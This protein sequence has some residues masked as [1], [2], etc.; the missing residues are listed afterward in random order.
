MIRRLLPIA[1]LAVALLVPVSARAATVHFGDPHASADSASPRATLHKAR[2]ALLDG[3]AVRTGA[4]IT[5]LLKQ[6]ALALPSLNGAERKRAVGLL[7]RPTAGEGSNGELEYEAAEQPS[8]CSAHFCVHWV[9]TTEDAPPLADSN[10]DGT[11]DYVETMSGVFEYVY[12]VENVQLGWKPPKSDGTRGCLGAPTAACTGKTDVYI[13]EVGSQGIYGY[14]APDPGQNSYHQFAYLVMDDDYTKTE[15]PTYGGD[16]LKPMEVT[17]AHEYNHVLQFNY[18]TGQDTWVFESTATWMEDRVYTDVNDYL[19]YLKPWS[20]MTSVPLTYFSA[21]D[22]Q[23]KVYGDVVWPRWIQAHYGE[24]AIRDA[25]AASRSTTPKSFGPAAYNASLIPR[26]SS[27]FKSFS[28]FAADTAEWRASSSP[29]A[30]GVT[31]PDVNRAAP[32]STS[33][34]ITL[35]ADE[36]GAAGELSHAAYVLIDVEP[37]TALPRLKLTVNTP[38]G[39]RMAFALIGRTGDPVNGT[40]TPFLKLLPNGGPGTITI[41]NP[42]QYERITAAVINADTSQTRYSQIAGDWLWTKDDQSINTRVSSDF[43]APRVTHR[44][45]KPGTRHASRYGHASVTFSER[46]FELTTRSVKLVAP[47]GRSVRAKLSL[48]TK[49]HNAHAEA[50]GRKFVLKPLSPLRK[51]TRYELRLSRDLR[52]YG[53][54]ALPSSELKFAFRTRR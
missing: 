38:R 19:Q 14:A 50:G 30:E 32:D 11:P 44:W 15:F 20:K 35:T 23:L 36:V 28:A 21:S 9:K 29:F 18:D 13:K 26:G 10:H 48:T 45:P 4:E 12:A 24:N 1:L 43:H 6:L 7:A 53:G 40:A 41:D 54:N 31:F 47:N 39:T 2:T 5:P 17:A 34:P 46:M 51:N 25:W 22:N 42:S 49:G 27:F 33:P 8:L 3:Q 37:P 52:D 16:P